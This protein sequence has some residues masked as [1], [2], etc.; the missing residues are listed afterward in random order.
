MALVKRIGFTRFSRFGENLGRLDAWEASHSDGLDGT[1]QITV[2][3]ADDVQKGDYIVWVDARGITHEHVVDDVKREHGEDDA[4]V[5]T[6]TAINSI[7]ELWDG[8]NDDIRPSGT[9]EV[10]LGRVLSGTRWSV[11]T[12]DQPGTASATFYHQSPRESIAQ[13]I[14]IWG[15]EIETTVVTDGTKVTGRYVGIRSARGNQSSPKRFTWTK[16]IVNISRTVGSENPKTRVY[17]Y[18][19][20][21]ETDSGG[22]GRRLTFESVNNGKAYVEDASATLVWGHPNG[23]G[24]IS[25]SCT[26]Y[27]NEQCEDPSQLLSETMAY[28]DEVKSPKVSYTANVIDLHAFGRSWEGVGAGDSVSIIDK[29]FCDEGIRLKGRVSMVERNLIDGTAVVTFG[30]LVDAMADMW[31]GVSS[32]LRDSESRSAAYDAVASAS[33]GWLVQLQRALNDQFNA[34]GTYKVENFDIGTVYSNVPI[35]KDTGLPLAS[36]SGMW[37]VNISGR[38][39]RLAEKLA[40]DG[41]WDWRTFIT[42]A[43]VNA[44]C[45]NGG[46]ISGNHIKGGTIEGSVL[47][48]GE[49]E[50]SVYR[51]VQGDSYMKIYGPS[52]Y[53][54]DGDIALEIEP[55]G[56]MIGVPHPEHDIVGQLQTYI[57]RYGIKATSAPREYDQGIVANGS[58]SISLTKIGGMDW[59]SPVF[60]QNDD[61]GDSG[62]CVTSG[63]T[64][65]YKFVWSLDSSYLEIDTVLGT[66]GLTAWKSDERDKEQIED[67][68]V[69]ATDVIKSIRHRSFKWKDLT[70][71]L[72]ELHEGAKCACGYIAQEMRDINRAFTLVVAEGTKGERMQISAPNVIPYITKALQELD[73]RVCALEEKEA[74]REH[75]DSRT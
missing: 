33:P 43:S 68:C 51:Y 66:Y 65:N 15:G 21:V 19:K 64:N 74:L 63:N 17:G 38:G 16:D 54:T 72:G 37:A 36:T 58:I 48:G 28:L 56:L 71:G 53:T 18:G 31:Q 52:L 14:G 20:G 1:D 70:D 41:Q 67:S 30:N 29:G 13:I 7:A 62:W 23:S 40:S 4:V 49:I 25:P 59:S 9:V 34:V 61:T 5:T 22:F 10:A 6:F 60:F 50:G 73:E 35:D 8:W 24:G 75:A 27:V 57:T 2:T 69:C 32:A 12:C 45:I 55:D 46:T 42:G 39:I 11:G 47:K 44:D 3:C 26:S